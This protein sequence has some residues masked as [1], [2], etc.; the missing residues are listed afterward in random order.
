MSSIL[1][2]FKSEKRVSASFYSLTSVMVKG[3]KQSDTETLLG[4]INCFAYDSA[5]GATFI[6]EKYREITDVILLVEYGDLTFT[7][8]DKCKVIYNNRIYY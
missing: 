6:N 4:T 2:Y 5:N 7:I 3:R 8:T 1:K